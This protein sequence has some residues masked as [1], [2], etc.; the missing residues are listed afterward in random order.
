[1]IN[2]FLL[3]LSFLLLVTALSAQAVPT[4]VMVRAKGKDAKFIG[5]SIGGAYVQIRDD[6]S[7]ELLAQGL[8]E[9]STGNTGRIMREAHERGDQIADENTAGFLA[10]IPLE[11]PRF[12]TIEVTAPANQKQA[13]VEASTQ[14]W[15]IPGKHIEG[16][17]IIL[18]IP[19]MVINILSPQTHQF[20]SL[21]S[22]E[23]GLLPI[24]ANVVMMCG[25][26]IS[27]GGLW[28]AEQMEVVAL[29]KRNG[30]PLVEVPLAIRDQVNT[31]EGE[32]SVTEGGQY[33]VIVYAY[34]ESSGN[35]GVAHMNW[36]VQ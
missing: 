8:T 21:E 29:V 4:R 12:V 32:L 18:E 15:L 17:G 14:V 24:K 35:T 1:M 30:E 22:L 10:T 31:F 33:E 13:A 2:R 28:D 34:Q 19:G 16:D 20:I 23:D 25:C 9:G 7:G 11:E 5:S 6:R 3:L 26:T 27:N 36:V